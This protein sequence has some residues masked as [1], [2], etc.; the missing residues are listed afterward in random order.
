MPTM[1]EVE[2]PRPLDGEEVKVAVTHKIAEAI[3]ASLDRHCAL[4]GKAYPKF[5]AQWEIHI[6]L[7]N[8]GDSREVVARGLL[9]AEA[10]I[11]NPIEIELEGV[12][13]ETPPNVI[14]KETDQ[15]IP[16]QLIDER[17]MQSEKAV[18]YKPK[19][20]PG[21]PPKVR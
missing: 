2:L 19:R 12:I 6:K 21:R 7:D 20:G 8:Y 18:F 17:G 5:S 15:A 11:E 4:Y 3:M 16:T 14:R 9:A 13:D 1:T 10:V